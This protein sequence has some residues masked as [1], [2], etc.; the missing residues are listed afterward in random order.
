[1]A[2]TVRNP[3]SVRSGPGARYRW[4][5]NL[6]R[7]TR[8]EVVESQGQWRKLSNGGWILGHY[9]TTDPVIAIPN[10]EVIYGTPPQQAEQRRRVAPQGPP[11]FLFFR[12]RGS[13]PPDP[14]TPPPS[15]RSM[16]GGAQP[17]RNHD[18]AGHFT[19]DEMRRHEISMQRRT[20]ARALG[21]LHATLMFLA[22]RY[23]PDALPRL[24]VAPGA[25]GVL[26]GDAPD[27]ISGRDR[28]FVDQFD[29]ARSAGHISQV[30]RSSRWISNVPSIHEFRELERYPDFRQHFNHAVRDQWT[31]LAEEQLLEEILLMIVQELIQRGLG[32]ALRVAGRPGAGAATRAAAGGTVTTIRAAYTRVLH[33]VRLLL[34]SMR[35]RARALAEA[36]RRIVPS[37][38][39]RVRVTVFPRVRSGATLPGV[40]SPQGGGTLRGIG[41]RAGGPPPTPPGGPPPGGGGAAAGGGGSGLRT[42]PLAESDVSMILEVAEEQRRLRREFPFQFDSGGSRGLSVNETWGDGMLESYEAK[43][44]QHAGRARVGELPPPRIQGVQSRRHDPRDMPTPESAPAA[45]MTTA[46]DGL[47]RYRAGQLQAQ[48][49]DSPHALL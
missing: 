13:D 41:P 36:M 42:E 30:G 7:G 29:D 24:E 8:V 48:G 40:G 22:Q 44:I 17:G 20:A 9:L 47:G 49:S 25:H 6:D 45:T 3:V 34:V 43:W 28:E 31:Y 12:P 46:S 1:M 33:H 18:R 26:G 4:L 19:R 35:T 37:G 14:P 38:G 2:H 10:T 16:Q 23:N 11:P 5:R 32:R 27:P 39:R 15:A 21:R